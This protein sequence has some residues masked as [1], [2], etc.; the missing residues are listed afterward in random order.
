M[1]LGLEWDYKNTEVPNGEE[2][3]IDQM[4][5]ATGFTA[6]TFSVLRF[7]VKKG[8]IIES[9]SYDYKCNNRNAWT[10]SAGSNRCFGSSIF[11]SSMDFNHEQGKV[12]SVNLDFTK[13]AQNDYKNKNKVDI[14]YGDF[15]FGTMYLDISFV[16]AD[17]DDKGTRTSDILEI[18]DLGKYSWTI[19]NF[20]VVYKKA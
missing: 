18:E 17:W 1:V 6:D 8:Y 12:Y 3:I 16:T 11:E 2:F 5:S 9:I 4:T 10:S 20:K 14:T 15:S 7:N 13:S 19:S